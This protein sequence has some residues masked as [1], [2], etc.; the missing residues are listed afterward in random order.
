MRLKLFFIFLACSLAVFSQTLPT[1]RSTNWQLAGLT[2]VPFT[3]SDTIN[4]QNAGGIGDGITINDSLISAIIDSATGNSTT[5]FFA[6]GIYLFS[7]PIYL[8]ENLI[9]YGEGFANTTLLFNLNDEKHLIYFE[10]GTPLDTIEILADLLKD[11]TR[12][13]T[14]GTNTLQIGDYIRIVENDSSFITSTWALNYSGQI[15]EIADIQN[16]TVF[17]SSPFRREFSVSKN[18]KMVKLDLKSNMGIENLKIERLDTTTGQKSNIFMNNVSNCWVK[19]IESY[20]CNYAHVEISS[21]TNIEISGC[22][23]HEA[24]NYGNGGKAYGVMVHFGSGE[25]L[26]TE[27]QFNT[28]RH[29]MILQGGANGNNFSYNYS[30]NP[31]WTDVF[32]PANSA[33]DIVLHGNYPYANLFEGNTVQ[34]IVIDDSHGINGPNNTFFRNRAEL[35]GIFMNNNPASDGQN[36]IGNEI[37][38][39]G[40]LMGNY[41]LSG[42]N[43][44]EYGNNKLGTVIPSGTNILYDSSLYLGLIP[45]YYQNNPPWP[46][47]GLPNTISSYTIEAEENYSLG[48]YTKCY[49]DSINP[50]DT[51]QTDTSVFVSELNKKLQIT[52][53]PNPTNG[54]VLLTNSNNIDLDI[55]KIEVMSCNG[56]LVKSFRKMHEIDLNQYKDG[57]YFIRVFFKESGPVTQKIVKGSTS[58]K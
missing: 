51:S 12:A 22:Y 27:N 3:S 26:V 38:N 4:F 5:V 20:R 33:G 37:T 11:S 21:S 56:I 43:H 15:M 16:N 23:F 48:E 2:N 58:N 50:T 57:L 29:S 24:F 42:S 19:C 39:N 41:I 45:A 52:L 49:E 34:H 31:Y 46:P 47:I 32:L 17:F 55:S 18:V 7:S 8:K 36:F 10:G 53:Y 1:N 40:L 14:N 13:Q 25:C 30:I 6:S 28:L 54:R 35:Y 44:F 9:L